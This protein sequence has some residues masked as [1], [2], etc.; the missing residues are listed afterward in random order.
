[1]NARRRKKE[2]KKLKKKNGEN[3]LICDGVFWQDKIMEKAMKKNV[4]FFDRAS[5]IIK[6]E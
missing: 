3:S 6:K 4:S 1:M 2:K 5:A